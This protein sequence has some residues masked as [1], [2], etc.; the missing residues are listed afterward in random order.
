MIY[1][2]IASQ[3]DYNPTIEPLNSALGTMKH[4]KSESSKAQIPR[5]GKNM[6]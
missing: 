5:R 2:K 4:E 6:L 1:E 3:L